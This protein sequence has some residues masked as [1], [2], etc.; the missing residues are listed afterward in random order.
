MCRNKMG[1]GLRKSFGKE[2]VSKNKET[3]LP[4]LV[5]LYSRRFNPRQYHLVYACSGL[6]KEL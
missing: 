1:A 4:F 2:F 3:L 6:S 5:L